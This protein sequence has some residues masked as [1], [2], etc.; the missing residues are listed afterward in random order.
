MLDLSAT[1]EVSLATSDKRDALYL[2]QVNDLII[3]LTNKTGRPLVLKGGAA[4]REDQLPPQ[5]PSSFYVA[6]GDALT[7]DQEARVASKT[8]AWSVQFFEQ[9]VPNVALV[10]DRDVPL[11]IGGS[12]VV[13]LGNIVVSGRVRP[14]KLAIDCCNLPGLDPYTAN[15]SLAIQNPPSAGK[16]ILLAPGFIGDDTSV[17]VTRDPLHPLTSAVAFRFQNVAREP[18][19]APDSQPS[20]NIWFVYGDP[21]GANALTT[22]NASTSIELTATRVGADPSD[23]QVWPVQVNDDKG[24]MWTLRPPGKNVLDVDGSLELAFSGIVTA[25]L[26]G[27]TLLYVQFTGLAGYNDACFPMVFEKCL[28]VA[29]NWLRADR[30]VLD[31][32]GTPV[33]VTLSWDVSAAVALHLD[34]QPLAHDATSQQQVLASTHT[35]WLS[36]TGRGGSHAEASIQIQGVD[37]FLRS[38]RFQLANHDHQVFHESDGMWIS[39]TDTVDTLSLGGSG[40]TGNYGWHITGYTGNSRHQ[41][42]SIDQSGGYAVT[43]ARSGTQVTAT[44]SG[45]S[46]SLSLELR[47]ATLVWLNPVDTS[48]R[49]TTFVPG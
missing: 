7:T 40:N 46:A 13:T 18:V 6:F 35:Y 32:Y 27:R 4:V 29:I 8:M 38:T 2:D 42:S 19:S 47:D 36:A 44:A 33:A 10:P 3:T 12:V 21:P 41:G 28:P 5:G 45:G 14:A 17:L 26:P 31:P 30:M 48:R 1:L 34:G 25:L 20:I 43:W 39:D 37:D 16:N 15:F 9:P 24:R 11:D 23:R 22:A 49:N